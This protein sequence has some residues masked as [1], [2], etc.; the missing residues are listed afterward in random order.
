MVCLN[1]CSSEPLGLQ[2]RTNGIVRYHSYACAYTCVCACVCACAYVHAYASTRACGHVACVCVVQW[3][4]HGIPD[5]YPL[6][7]GYACPAQP[8]VVCWRSLTHDSAARLFASAFFASCA[9]ASCAS[10]PAH[11]APAQAA[12]A[13]AAA[14]LQPVIRAAFLAACQA[15][16]NA[17]VKLKTPQSTPAAAAPLSRT[18]PKFVLAAPIPPAAHHAGPYPYPHHAGLPILLCDNADGNGGAVLVGS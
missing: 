11:T 6:R 2:L 9:K 12:Q 13:Q 18:F 5:R 14:S 1:G 17:T 10:S 4:P 8:F 3:L 7:R 16:K 15:V